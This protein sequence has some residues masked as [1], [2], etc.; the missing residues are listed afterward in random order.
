MIKINK[1]QSE[2]TIAELKQ[3]YN[4]NSPYPIDSFWDAVIIGQTP[5]YEI[6][7][8]GRVVGHCGVS[9]TGQLV[10]LQLD[11]E[12]WG[13]A[14]QIIKTLIDE[15]RVE[16]ALVAT[17]ESSLLAACIDAQKKIST[18]CFLW[19]DQQRVEP[20]APPFDDLSF[21]HATMNDLD[22]ITDHF[23]TPFEGYYEGVIDRQQLFVFYSGSALLG[24]GE[25]RRNQGQIQFGEVGIMVVPEHRRKGIATYVLAQLKQVCYQTG[26]TP[27]ALCDVE[28]IASQRALKKAGFV[29]RQRIL[30][31][32]F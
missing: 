7:I 11:D 19:N 8:Q 16:E 27:I 2:A 4:Q 12:G 18:H 17:F 24:A 15:Y 14:P 3:V 1:I 26:I 30:S 21:R 10:R 29:S 13:H 31:I 5:F 28:N 22:T 23:E 25:C 20:P 32:H 6:E 9:D